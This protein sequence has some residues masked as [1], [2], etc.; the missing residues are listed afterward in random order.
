MFMRQKS[1]KVGLDGISTM[2]RGGGTGVR[3]DDVV[4]V[5]QQYMR[6]HVLKLKPTTSG[7][8]K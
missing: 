3:T 4:S 2:H 5:L 6:P 7:K 8:P 1:R